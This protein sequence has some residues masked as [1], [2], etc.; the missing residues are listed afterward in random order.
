MIAKIKGHHLQHGTLFPQLPTLLDD[1][2]KVTLVFLHVPIKRPICLMCC[3]LKK[4]C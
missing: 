1:Y 3:L 2:Y 4:N